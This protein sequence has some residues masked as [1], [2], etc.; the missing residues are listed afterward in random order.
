MLLDAL[1]L[2]V[3][4]AQWSSAEHRSAMRMHI[5]W[6]IGELSSLLI[7]LEDADSPAKRSNAPTPSP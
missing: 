6:F 2:D 5:G 4:D 7:E 1:R 3:G